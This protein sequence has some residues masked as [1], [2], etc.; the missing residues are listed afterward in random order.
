MGRPSRR[1]VVCAGVL[2]ALV[3]LARRTA[4]RGGERHRRLWHASPRHS[5]PATA[6]APDHLAAVAHHRPRVLDVFHENFL[7]DRPVDDEA[8][9][10]AAVEEGEKRLAVAQAA[11]VAHERGAA[12]AANQAGSSAVRAANAA[13]TAARLV[14]SARYA[15]GV[16]ANG[17][18]GTNG[19]NGNGLTKWWSSFTK[20][21]NGVMPPLMRKPSLEQPSLNHYSA[22]FRSPRR[23]LSIPCSL[24]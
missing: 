24:T 17:T 5:V 19:A 3:A 9:R 16:A 22:M 10:L 20:K 13:R 7:Q 11:L 15:A 12:E 23:M 21:E 14:A 6:L 4:Q 1:L 8:R 18:N 2:V